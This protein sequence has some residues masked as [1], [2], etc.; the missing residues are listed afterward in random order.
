VQGCLG[1]RG[2]F[3]ALDAGLILMTLTEGLAT[4]LQ[5]FL[6]CIARLYLLLKYLLHFK[7]FNPD[8]ASGLFRLS[9]TRKQEVDSS[10]VTGNTVLLTDD[11]A[12]LVKLGLFRLGLIRS[13]AGGSAAT[14]ACNTVPGSDDI[15]LLVALA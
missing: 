6:L 15:A 8:D 2:A 1:L 7:H 4:V 11:I 12:P 10:A 5:L 14:V 13:A 3:S 9:L